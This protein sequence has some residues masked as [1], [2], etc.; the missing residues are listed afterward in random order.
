MKLRIIAVFAAI[1]AILAPIT[2]CS[3]GTPYAP[4]PWTL[5]PSPTA[6]WATSTAAG[7]AKPAEVSTTVSQPSL[8]VNRICREWGEAKGGWIRPC[9][10]VKRSPN[11]LEV[12]YWVELKEFSSP[13]GA[14]YWLNE[15]ANS[16]V[17]EKYV[18]SRQTCQVNPREY[19]VCDPVVTILEKL[20][21]E[22]YAAAAVT[23][24]AGIPPEAE[25]DSPDTGLM[26]PD[27]MHRV[28]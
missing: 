23:L 11:G 18:Y 4:G 14:A 27:L 19:R 2:G 1:A 13:A 6:P 9:G 21:A 5:S 3:S 22:L 10:S 28:R 24:S 8:P 17:T 26:T 15:G 16:K 20:P 25:P 7:E 12:T